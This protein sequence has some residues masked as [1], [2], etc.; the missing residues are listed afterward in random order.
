[1]TAGQ[2]EQGPITL[3]NP[4]GPPAREFFTDN[5]DRFGRFVEAWLFSEDVDALVAG[6]EFTADEAI[7][8]DA[9]FRRPQVVGLVLRDA[10][11]STLQFYDAR[12]GLLLEEPAAARE[13]LRAAGFRIRGIRWTDEEQVV[14]LR[15]DRLP[16]ME[17]RPSLFIGHPAST[18]RE[19]DLICVVDGHPTLLVSSLGVG[20]QVDKWRR[21]GHAWVAEPVEMLVFIDDATAAAAGYT[22]PESSAVLVGHLPS[23][24]RVV[25]RGR[26]GRMWWMPVWAGRRVEDLMAAKAIADDLGLV[27]AGSGGPLLDRARLWWTQVTSLGR[28][29]I[30]LVP[31]VAGGQRE[32]GG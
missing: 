25:V 27:V 11:G 32:H 12:A 18:S 20:V 29:P 15:R 1:V 4:A 28:D 23:A 22:R 30:R 5:R 26:E 6:F 9:R 14:H 8:R 2:H 24:F 21:Y 17:V 16:P 19:G 31:R 13:V 10:Q 3:S 7:G